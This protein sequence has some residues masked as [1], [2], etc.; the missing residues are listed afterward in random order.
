MKIFTSIVFSLILL[1]GVGFAAQQAH[2]QV[3]GGCGSTAGYSTTTGVSCNGAVVIPIGCTSTAGFNSN[4]GQPCN[5]A[6]AQMNGYNGIT[7]GA[8]NFLNGCVSTN[9]YSA[10]T[11]Y[12]CN[13]VVN[14]VVY[15]GF[16]VTTPVV[17]NPGSPGLPTT[18]AGQ[19]A[20]IN[21]AVLLGSA[22]VAFFGVR[23]I[24][25]ESAG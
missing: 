23:T 1:L 6:T 18:G 24:V 4:T 16:P 17:I 19:N 20:L 3:A 25:R 21:I 12:P 5:G 8:N 11:G 10:T 2:A 15:N 22:M 9:G 13:M 7:V 14:G